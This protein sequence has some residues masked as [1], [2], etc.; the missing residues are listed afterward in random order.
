M[1]TTQLIKL[2]EL[3]A[4]YTNEELYLK[5]NIENIINKITCKDN[6]CNLCM[7]LKNGLCIDNIPF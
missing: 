4:T 2:K 7:S 3:L 6:Q 1:N 5:E